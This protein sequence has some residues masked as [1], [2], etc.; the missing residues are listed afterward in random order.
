MNKRLKLLCKAIIRQAMSGYK[1]SRY[2]RACYDVRSLLWMGI[3]S[4]LDYI[5]DINEY[6]RF[7]MRKY[8]YRMMTRLLDI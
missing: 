2:N 4:T 7:Q 6:S 8:I 1:E 5:P 3:E